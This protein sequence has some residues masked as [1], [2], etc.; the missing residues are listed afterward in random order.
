MCCASLFFLQ[1][2]FAESFAPQDQ[3]GAVIYA[4]R[5]ER[6][7]SIDGQLD[8]AIWEG[9]CGPTDFYQKE[10]L[11]GQEA[12]EV[13]RVCIAYDQAN[14]YIGVEF[15]D[16]E[17]DE[18]RASELQRDSTLEGDDSF[19]VILDTFHDHRNAFLFR[20]N[21]LGTRSDAVI[22]NES[23]RL[24]SEWDEQWTE[25]S[26]ITEGGWTAEISIPFKIL[27][28]S[29]DEEQTWGIN[30]ERV[31]K[32]KNEFVYWSG[33]D[34]NF[35]FQHVSQAGQLEG[36][37][38]I[39]QAERLRIRPYVVA[40]V[41]RIAVGP[42]IGTR[43]LWD[44]GI[45]D[46]KFALTSNLTADLTFNPDFGQVE[47]D[48]QR[49]NLTRFSLFFQEK[50]Q[51]FIEGADSLK[52][53]V[54]LLHFGPPPLELFYSRKIGLSEA[55]QPISIVGGGKLTGKVGGFD[56]GVLNVQ[57]DDYQQEP[58]ENFMVAR[59]RKEMLGRSYIGAIFT[60]R[61]SQGNANRGGPHTLDSSAANLRWILR[62]MFMLPK[63]VTVF[64][65]RLR[66]A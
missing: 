33:W 63:S 5:V 55:G 23:D 53:R 11:E 29:A 42:S 4:E 12:T 38:N 21:P 14:L 66:W 56:L 31:I 39:I 2:F 59:V 64:P 40:G 49:V 9:M 27:R 25:A 57:T 30:F 28:F 46:L 7:P 37:S 48:A 58:G 54:S 1:K 8:E 24:S 26:A 50:R 36:L 61:Q 35:L 34:R 19:T 13:T 10:P 65:R 44:G 17:P 6:P 16:S 51:F 43:R 20:V 3:D 41:E 22:R 45:D 60:N 47:V 32:R 52:M 18:I 15:R 62:F